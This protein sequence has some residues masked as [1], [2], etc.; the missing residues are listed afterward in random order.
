MRPSRQRDALV[1]RRDDADFRYRVVDEAVEGDG[2]ATFG[3]C[4]WLGWWPYLHNFC[5]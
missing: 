4:L 3:V 5:F 1:T 2:E